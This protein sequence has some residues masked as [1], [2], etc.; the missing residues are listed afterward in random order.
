VSQKRPPFYFS[1]NCNK[2]NDFNDLFVLNPEKICHQYLVHL[3]NSPVYCSHFT[4][5]NPKKLFFNSII[6]T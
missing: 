3:P 6:R 5:G 2:L 1:D 4:L